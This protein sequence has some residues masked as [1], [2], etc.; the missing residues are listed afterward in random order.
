MKPLSPFVKESEHVHVI[1]DTP[2]GSRNKYHYDEEK[3]LFLLKSVLPVGM[4]FPFDFGFIPGTR[5]ADGDPVDILVLLD[6]PATQGSLVIA[7]LI[8]VIE[9]EQT[10]QGKTSRNDRLIGIGTASRDYRSVESLDQLSPD[11]P[12]QIEHFFIS[13]NELA[14]KK[15]QPL[16]RAGPGR[17]RALVEAAREP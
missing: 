7:R 17:A 4:S 8:A 9:A 1:I 5:A 12:D 10:E 13:Y 6:Q 15:F 2:K 11:L 16:A 3:E 14:G